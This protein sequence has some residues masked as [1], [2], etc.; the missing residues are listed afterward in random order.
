MLAY[1][2]DGIG[3]MELELFIERLDTM[4]EVYREAFLL[5]FNN[6]LQEL[7][8]RIA[9]RNCSFPDVGQY[10]LQLVAVGEVIAQK[11]FQ[12]VQWRAE[13]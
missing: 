2:T 10:Q 12:I 4:E 3:E 9:I 11:K 7:R 6:P 13:T 1:L 5:R 8:C